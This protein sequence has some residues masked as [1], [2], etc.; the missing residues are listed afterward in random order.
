MCEMLLDAGYIDNA[1]IQKQIAAIKAN[2]V[3]VYRSF[4]LLDKIFMIVFN[5]R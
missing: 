5:D 3:M 1:V 2:G 4:L